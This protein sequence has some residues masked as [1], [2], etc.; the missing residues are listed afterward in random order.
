MEVTAGVDVTKWFSLEANAAISKNAIRDFDEVIETY[1]ADWNDLPATTV[2]YDNSTLAFSPSVLLNGF[3]DFHVKG[4]E[5][6]WHTNF[7]SRQYLD[8]TCN[9]DRSLPKFTQTNI[10]LGY[11]LPIGRNEN[12]KNKNEKLNGFGSRP[13]ILF[14]VDLRNI[15]NRRYASSGWV[16]SAIV[17]SDYPEQDRYY[18]IGYIPM[19][20]F[21]AMGSVTI[22]F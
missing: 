22:K 7:V 8:N 15:F 14:G 2:H 20:G 6:T 18:Q 4:F 3:A 13:H 1:D 12:L 5:A 19:S 9:K 16:Y 11:T 17:G 10:H 21:T